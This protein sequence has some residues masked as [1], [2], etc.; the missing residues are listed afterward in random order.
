MVQFAKGHRN[1]SKAEK[2]AIDL[3]NAIKRLS[4]AT[5]TNCLGI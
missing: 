3:L 4:A 1:S 2:E 5:D